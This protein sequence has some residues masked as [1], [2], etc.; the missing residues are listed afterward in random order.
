MERRGPGQIS[1]TSDAQPERDPTSFKKLRFSTDNFPEHKRIEAY[2][3]VY[4][5]IIRKHDIEPIGDRPFNFEASLCN[6]P[7]L[8]LASSRIS[9]CRRSDGPQHRDSDDLI[10]G[11]GLSGGCI[12][13]QC[14]REAVIGVGEAVLTSSADPAVVMIASASQAVSLRISRSDLGTADLD[15][16]LSRRLPRNTEGLLLLTGYVG[17]ILSADALATPQLRELVVA[18]VHDLVLLTLGVKGE[19][20]QLAQQRGVR[21]ARR[22]AI[23]RAIDSRS[24]DPGVNAFAIAAQL[25]VSPRYV[26]LLLEETGKSFTH[27]LLEKRLKKAS[28]LLC[29]PRW[30][31]RKI[32]DIALQAG[33]GDLSYFSR[34]FRRYYGATPSDIREAARQQNRD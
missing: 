21:A 4:G 32:A 27:H 6:L 3:E 33:F 7:G 15:A 34:A 5:R 13:Q 14:D 30:F 29:D 22:T 31:Q 8:G 11:I 17:E 20:Y 9:P 16:Y 23:L 19:A 26:H 10:L 1:F 18:H 25:G 12:V 24:G 28:A 2:R